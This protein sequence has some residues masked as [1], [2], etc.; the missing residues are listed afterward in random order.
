MKESMTETS[1]LLLLSSRCLGTRHLG[2]LTSH[3]PSTLAV[4]VLLT[5]GAYPE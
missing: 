3:R 5:E 1:R 2:P 4:L